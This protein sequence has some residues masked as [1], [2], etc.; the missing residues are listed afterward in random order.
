M[1][2]Y[3]FPSRDCKNAHL[4]DRNSFFIELLYLNSPL[5]SAHQL[6]GGGIADIKI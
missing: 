6:Q 5:P 1:S 4:F 2:Y 3:F